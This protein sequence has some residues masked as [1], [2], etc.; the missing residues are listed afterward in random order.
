MLGN[1]KQDWLAKRLAELDVGDIPAIC[2]AAG[3]LTLR[4]MEASYRWKEILAEASPAPAARA[5][6]AVFRTTRPPRPD[7]V[8]VQSPTFLSHTPD[9]GVHVNFVG[10]QDHL[11][12]I[13]G[14]TDPSECGLHA[15]DA[16]RATHIAAPCSS[17]ERSRCPVTRA[18]AATCPRGMI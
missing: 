11:G 16:R 4:C 13:A 5:D 15:D 2:A 14:Q 8:T 7:Q 17:P 1:Y 18:D 3:I 6:L 12:D 9:P 10:N